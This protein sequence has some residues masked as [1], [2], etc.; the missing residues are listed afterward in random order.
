M[1]I[2]GH[3]L[4]ATVAGGVYFK[5]HT[6][7]FTYLLIDKSIIRYINGRGKWKGCTHQ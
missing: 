7:I 3:N 5:S 6:S 2:N 4:T 1:P